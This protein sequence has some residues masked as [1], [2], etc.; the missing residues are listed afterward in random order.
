MRTAPGQGGNLELVAR[1]ADCMHNRGWAV[2][3]PKT[4]GEEGRDVPSTNQ[5][6]PGR[7]Q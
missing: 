1:F 2:N 3:R 7:F 6:G 5:Q 4:E